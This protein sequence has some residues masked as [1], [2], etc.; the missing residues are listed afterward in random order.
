M[1]YVAFATLF[2][3]A[4]A[5]YV[6]VRQGENFN[7]QVLALAD[8]SARDRQEWAKE[9]HVLCNR[10]QAPS[11]LPVPMQSLSPDEVTAVEDGMA[12]EWAAIGGHLPENVAAE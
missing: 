8:L 2:V 1:T 5:L 11:A 7:R 3:L 10:I 6:I 12:A 4:V 9:R